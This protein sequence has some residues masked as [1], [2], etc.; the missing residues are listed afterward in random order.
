MPRKNPAA[1]VAAAPKWT[2]EDL[3]ASRQFGPGM[4]GQEKYDAVQAYV[5]ETGGGMFGPA[6]RNSPAHNQAGPIKI[7]DGKPIFAHELET[8]DA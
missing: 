7:V 5:A 2:P 6:L 8:A 1:S 3:M 4:I